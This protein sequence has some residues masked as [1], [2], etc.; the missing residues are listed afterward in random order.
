[1]KFVM[2]RNKSDGW[3][4]PIFSKLKLLFTIVKN[5]SSSKIWPLL[6]SVHYYLVGLMCRFLRFCSCSGTFLQVKCKLQVN[7]PTWTP[8]LP[9]YSRV[10]SS[11]ASIIGHRMAVRDSLIRVN[12]GS[13]LRRGGGECR[14]KCVCA[15]V[16]VNGAS[17]WGWGG[18]CVVWG[19][20]GG[21]RRLGS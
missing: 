14:A 19:G 20:G 1:M 10:M 21:W 12:S 9:E 2:G 3:S 17:E 7:P 5:H 4:G 11:M 13:S 16:W 8:P 6:D 18:I 15:C